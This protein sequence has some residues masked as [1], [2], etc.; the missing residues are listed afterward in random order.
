MKLIYLVGV[1]VALVVALVYGYVQNLL[2]LVH[3]NLS[4]AEFGAMEIARIIGLVVFP[5]GCILGYF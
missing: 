1:Q 3:T 5:L 4:L 2:V